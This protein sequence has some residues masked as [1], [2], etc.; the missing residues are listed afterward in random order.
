MMNWDLEK[1]TQTFLFKNARNIKLLFIIFAVNV[2]IYGQKIFSFSLA[3]DD[4][5]RF[6]NADNELASS[7]GRWAATLVNQY[8]FTNPIHILPYFNGLIGIFCFTVAGFLTA[9]I[10]KRT[11]ELEIAIITLL[12]SATP[13]V[14]DNMYFNTNISAWIATAIGIWGILLLNRPGNSNKF[15]GTLMLALS[16]GCYQTIIQIALALATIKLMIDLVESSSKKNLRMHILNFL[17]FVGLIIAAFATSTVINFLYMKFYHLQSNDRFEA[18]FRNNGLS[19]YWNRLLSMFHNVYGLRYFKAPLIIMYKTMA[20]LSFI[21]VALAI[22]KNRQN[23]TLKACSLLVLI[24]TFLITPWIINLPNLFDNGIPLRAHYTIGWFMAGFFSIQMICFKNRFKIFPILIGASLIIT[25]AFYINVFFD[26]AHRQT[27]ADIQTANQIATRIRIHPHFSEE[28]I[29]LRIV[30]LSS[31]STVKHWDPS[32][33]ALNADWS[34]YAIFE[35]HTDLDFSIMEDTEYNLIALKLTKQ[36][37]I[38]GKYPNKDSIYV[39]GNK[40]VLFLNPSEINH[41]ILM[42]KISNI[43]PTV[44]SYFHVYLT[45]NELI[46]FKSP[47]EKVDLKSPFFL[48][49]YDQSGIEDQVIEHKSFL[50]ETIIKNESCIIGKLL[51]DV[52]FSKIYTGQHDKPYKAKKN[53]PYVIFWKTWIESDH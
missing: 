53:D 16:I 4:Y 8:I 41:D 19:A 38:L 47:C 6:T 9:K 28:P 48:H 11:N 3:T 13:M 36:S 7:M 1:S 26:A 10:L 24:F 40:V 51:P 46:Y 37:H 44:E 18:A 33:V 20:L 49:F 17:I 39:D 30:G 43:Q 29:Q 2:A 23:N 45:K 5:P 50:P 52:Q 35:N 42:N 34:K 27:M 14:A 25:S 21:G 15:S 12:V 32:Q 22:F 31:E